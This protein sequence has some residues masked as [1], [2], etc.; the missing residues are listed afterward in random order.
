MG[1]GSWG[2]EWLPGYEFAKSDPRFVFSDPKNPWELQLEDPEKYRRCLR[3][4][5]D[6]FEDLVEKLSPLIKRQDT[7]LRDSISPAERLA[8]AL[9]H[10]ATGETQE[11]L[12]YSFRLGQSTISGIIK[13]TCR[14]LVSVLQD[15]YLK[16]PDSKLAWKAVAYDYMERWNF[17]NCLGAMDGKHIRIDPPLQSGSSYFNYK[18]TFSIVLLALVDAQLRFIF[19]DVGTNGRISDR[20]IWNK[21]PLKHYLETSND[22]PPPSFLSDTE[23][24][25]PYVII[26]DEGFTLS[27]NV[28]IPYPKQQCTGKK[29]RRIYNYRLSRARRTSENGFGIMVS[30]FNILRSPLRYDPDDAR[31]I[32]LA[33]CCLHN[34]LR[35]HSVGRM[36]YT[37]PGYIDKEDERTGQLQYGEWRNEQGQGLLNLQHQ[38]GNRHASAAIAMRETLCEYFNTVGRVPDEAIR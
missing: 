25:F 18:E 30:R 6:I 37:P 27:T 35:S 1:G 9:R 10:L 8:V 4:N 33:I 2:I 17:P 16:F 22:I 31:W 29:E 19:V 7:H 14:A 20:G 21:C 28:M 23:Q 15:K 34:M 3:M 13:D 26:A 5:S 32:V 24:D 11:S 38:G 12:S 36:M